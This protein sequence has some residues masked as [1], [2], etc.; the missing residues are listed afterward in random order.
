MSAPANCLGSPE[1]V[2]QRRFKHSLKGSRN[3]LYGVPSSVGRA[4]WSQAYSE[5]ALGASQVGGAL[6]V[7]ACTTRLRKETLPRLSVKE[8]HAASAVRGDRAAQHPSCCG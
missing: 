2:S 4:S 6:V 1:A 5:G 7:E 8:K 3:L